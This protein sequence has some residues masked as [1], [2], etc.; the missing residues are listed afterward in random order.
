[1][2]FQWRSDVSS[3]LRHRVEVWVPEIHTS[4]AILHGMS[5]ET[6]LWTTKLASVAGRSLCG[7]WRRE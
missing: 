5:E 4:S 3:L 7:L 1:M 6:V 2:E